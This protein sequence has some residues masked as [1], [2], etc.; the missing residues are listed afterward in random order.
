MPNIWKANTITRFFILFIITVLL[1]F[2]AFAILY[3]GGEEEFFGIIAPECEIEQIYQSEPFSFSLEGYEIILPQGGIVA[4]LQFEDSSRGLVFLAQ[5]N[6]IKRRGDITVE[7]FTGGYLLVDEETYQQI[8]G[9][10]LFLPVENWRFNSELRHTLQQLIRNPVLNTFGFERMLLP[11]TGRS[12]LYLENDDGPVIDQLSVLESGHTARFVFYFSLFIVIVLLVIRLLT[13]DIKTTQAQ[14]AFL[15][16]PPSKQE[17]LWNLAALIIIFLAHLFLP[18]ASPVAN[19]LRGS[20]SP[21]F[22]CLYLILFLL[23]CFLAYKGKIPNPYQRIRWRQLPRSA[24]AAL[25]VAL[26]MIVFSGLRI[27]PLPGALLDVRQLLGSFFY[28]FLCAA[29][30]ELFWRELFQTTMVR[31]CGEKW[32]LMISTVVF[33]GVFFI[34]ANYHMTDAGVL[35]HWE[36]L[37]FLPGTA[38]FLGYIHQKGNSVMASSMLLAILF[39]LPRVLL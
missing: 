30:F 37:F 29:A 39:F 8:K 26:V 1:C 5:G 22:L 23:F 25:V 27:S 13:L 10:A 24:G 35:F 7:S 20:F 38:L 34:T 9:A 12:R 17:I 28:C 32:G 4:P 19:P 11:Q 14:A 15:Q 31:L 2:L 6:A 3:S 16:T 18:V 21:L 36:T 33:T